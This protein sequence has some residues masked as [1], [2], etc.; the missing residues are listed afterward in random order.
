MSDSMLRIFQ[1]EITIIIHWMTKYLKKD[2]KYFTKLL[3][4][5]KYYNY[6]KKLE[7]NKVF[8][9]VRYIYF[10]NQCTQFK[11]CMQYI[12]IIFCCKSVQ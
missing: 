11:N 3:P 6:G 1:F 8:S 5:L 9:N 12:F 10:Y 4:C 7:P 2:G